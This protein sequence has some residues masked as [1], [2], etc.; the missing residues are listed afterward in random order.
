MT[1]RIVCVSVRSNN[2][3]A[4]DADTENLVQVAS[5]SVDRLEDQI[6]RYWKNSDLYTCIIRLIVFTVVVCQFMWSLCPIPKLEPS[7]ICSPGSSLGR[8]IKLY[9]NDHDHDDE[10][11]TPMTLRPV[12]EGWRSQV[13]DVST[14][15]APRLL[16]CFGRTTMQELSNCSNSHQ[17]PM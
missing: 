8:W 15:S 7:L 2:L 17:L 1:S 11:A 16:E 14:N 6:G 12:V 10:V 9:P 4:L 13:F 5:S 3:G